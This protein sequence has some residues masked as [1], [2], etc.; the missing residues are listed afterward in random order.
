MIAVRQRNLVPDSSPDAV[1]ASA[2]RTTGQQAHHGRR[3]A[4]TVL[5][6]V[7]SVLDFNRPVAVLA[8]VILDLLDLDDPAGHMASYRKAYVPG[9]AL[10][11]SHTVPTDMS[12]TETAGVAEMMQRT[13]TP[14]RPR[15]ASQPCSTA[16]NSSPMLGA[17]RAMAPRTTHLPSTRPPAATARFASP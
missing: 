9:S 4:A 14:P 13:T 8:V 12:D 2:V 6:T 15:R 10:V 7:A 11:L 17:Q 5:N 1:P 16:T 3:A